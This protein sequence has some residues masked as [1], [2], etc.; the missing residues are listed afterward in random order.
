MVRV[1]DPAETGYR[2]G[3]GV[4]FGAR[5]RDFEPAAAGGQERD[6]GAAAGQ[7]ID[8]AVADLDKAAVHHGAA[9]DLQ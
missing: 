6:V 9:V 4:R 5:V 3:K 8:N 7:D 2:A 1:I